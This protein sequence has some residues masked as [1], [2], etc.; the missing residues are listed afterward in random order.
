MST[1]FAGSNPG[2]LSLSARPIC[3]SFIL[4][5]S[6]DLAPKL[7]MSSRSASLREISSPT[8]WMPSRLR[9]LY[10]RTVSSISSIGI[11]KLARFSCS[12]GDGP[13]SMPSASTF[14]SRAR[15]KSSTSVLPAEA[16][17]SRGRIDGLVS[18]STTSLSKSVRCSTRVASTR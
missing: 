8:V 3:A 18:T 4:T 12:C 11:E 16:I 17:A 9:Q 7:R 2:G 1:T 6:M 15:P 13:T 14:S 10:E 5:S